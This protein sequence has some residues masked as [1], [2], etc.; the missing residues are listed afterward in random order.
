MD[1]LKKIN[2]Y[3]FVLLVVLAIGMIGFSVYSLLIPSDAPDAGQSKLGFLWSMWHTIFF[4]VL[5]LSSFL[6]YKFWDK[7]FPA[8]TPLAILLLGFSFFFS[9]VTFMFGWISLLGLYGMIFALIVS[10]V[11]AIVNYVYMFNKGAG[12]LHIWLTISKI[13]L[14]SITLIVFINALLTRNFSGMA[15]S[16]SCVGLLMIVLGVEEFQKKSKVFFVLSI[17]AAFFLF[18]IAIQM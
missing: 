3:I 18:L 13:I 1:T 10:I 7:L 17:V 6:V 2:R 4:L 16:L 15:V 9:F 12:E 11:L 14:V 5:L 8:N